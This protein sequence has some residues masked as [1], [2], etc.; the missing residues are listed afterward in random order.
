[1]GS[2]NRLAREAR[3]AA[4]LTGM[5]PH[6][7]LLQIARGEIIAVKSIDQETGSINTQ[8]IIPDLEKRIDAAKA[9]APYY[10]PKMSTVEVIANVSD[11]ELDKIIAGAAAE[12]GVSVGFGG[13]SEAD[14]DNGAAQPRRARRAAAATT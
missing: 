3:E 14:E 4:L 11:D 8:Y 5:L 10:A 2:F 7:I 9:C 1:M 12:A 13:E 6:E